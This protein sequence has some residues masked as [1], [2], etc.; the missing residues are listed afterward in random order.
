M[1]LALHIQFAFILSPRHTKCSS[2][3]L[4]LPAKSTATVTRPPT[5]EESAKGDFINHFFFPSPFAQQQGSQLLMLQSIVH[6][7]QLI[8]SFTPVTDDRVIVYSCVTSLYPYTFVTLSLPVM[9]PCVMNGAG[10][11]LILHL[12]HL[13]LVERRKINETRRGKAGLDGCVVTKTIGK[14]DLMS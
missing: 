3:T 12:V 6:L 14:C 9:R 7:A 8:N 13:V 1:C 4:F 11:F 5:G 10:Q 2:F